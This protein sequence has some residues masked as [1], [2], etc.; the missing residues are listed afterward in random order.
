[1]QMLANMVFG[2]VLAGLSLGPAAWAENPRA[3]TRRLVS[4]V[5][6]LGVEGD[7]ARVTANFAIWH[8]QHQN[9]VRD[10][11]LHQDTAH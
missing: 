2:A 11:Y 3:R 4:N 8:F 9:A 10:H 7:T 5:R 1:M 6:L